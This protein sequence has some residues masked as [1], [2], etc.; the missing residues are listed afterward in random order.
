MVFNRSLGMDSS[1]HIIRC[2]AA[3]ILRIDVW[4]ARNGKPHHQLDAFRTA[5]ILM[6]LSGTFAMAVP[7]YAHPLVAV[8]SCNA[9]TASRDRVIS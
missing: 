8:M 2:S 1:R 4:A 6:H 5:I 3:E 7:Y 9:S